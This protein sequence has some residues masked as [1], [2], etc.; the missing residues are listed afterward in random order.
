M[1]VVATA[2]GALI[3]VFLNSPL[4][5]LP[6][7][8]PVFGRA[9]GFKRVLYDLVVRCLRLID[10]ESS[11]LSSF[12]SSCSDLRLSLASFTQSRQIAPR[13][14]ALVHRGD[15]LVSHFRQ[16]G[17]APF[18]GIFVRKYDGEM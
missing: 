8:M 11:D 4:L 5:P 1:I 15:S 12:S 14:S 3:G 13:F 18:K 17:G 16:T 6:L 7:G 2:L 10:L 9:K